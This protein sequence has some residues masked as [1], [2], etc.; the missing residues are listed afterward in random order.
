M[1]RT[2]FEYDRSPGWFPLELWSRKIR[3]IVLFDDRIE[4]RRKR[5]NLTQI[6][7]YHEKRK[8]EIL[9]SLGLPFHKKI[10]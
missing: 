3:K 9:E 10:A 5:H 7:R 4:Y 2:N 8:K 1:R 6:K